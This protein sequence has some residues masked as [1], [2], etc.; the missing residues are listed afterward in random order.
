MRSQHQRK[1]T[2]VSWIH[3]ICNWISKSFS[4]S[5]RFQFH[6]TCK[7]IMKVHSLHRNSI[8]DGH[9]FLQLEY[10]CK[11]IVQIDKERSWIQYYHICRKQL[12]IVEVSPNTVNTQVHT[13]R[14]DICL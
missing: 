9:L 12:V 10:L 13:C 7:S 11:E 8:Y 14:I 1:F 2:S 6:H 4:Y 3:P 5:R